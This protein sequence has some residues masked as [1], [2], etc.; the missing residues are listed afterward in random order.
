MKGRKNSNRKDMLQEVMGGE[1]CV[2]IN[3]YF[4]NG[5]QTKFLKEVFKDWKN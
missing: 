2:V 4:S 5:N 3:V 1:K